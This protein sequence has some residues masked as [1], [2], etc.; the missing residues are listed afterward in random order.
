M[1]NILF[2]HLISFGAILVL[3]A[4]LFPSV[5]LAQAGIDLVVH[6]VEG[7]PLE[8]KVGYT[9]SVYLS[10]LQT[11]GSA[12]NG[13]NK[14]SFK[15][16][17]D[18]HQVEIDSVSTSA[19]LP[20]N[21]LVLVDSSGSMQGTPIQDA[22]SAASSFISS[23]GEKD[24][25]AAAAFNEEMRFLSEFTND[26]QQVSAMMNSV[27]AVNL[28]STCLYDAAY[29]AVQKT[30]T[31]E[32]GRRAIVLLTDGKDYKAG[33][34]CSVHTL[35]DVIRLASEGSTRVPIFT[36]GLGDEIEEKGL[37]RLAEMSGGVYHFAPSSSQLQNIF[38]ALASQLRSEYVLTYTS[39]SAPG[40]HTVAV[41]IKYDNQTAQD[42]RAFTLSELPVTLTI[43]SPTEGQEIDGTTKVAVSLSG[44]GDL[45]EK[46]TF[47]LGETEIGSDATVPYELDYG[48]SSEQLGSQ[49]IT[50][51]A[52]NADGEEITGASV[53]VM[54]KKAAT[55]AISV[56]KTGILDNPLY[57]GLIAG[58]IILLAAVIVLLT[59]RKKKMEPVFN[60]GFDLRDVS[61]SSDP[62]T[63]D[64]ERPIMGKEQNQ[65]EVK[66]IFSILSSDD[67]GMI[68]QQLS[69]THFPSKVG[70]GSSNDIVISK[71]DAAVSRE[72]VVIDQRNDHT[73]ILE[74]FSKDENGNPKLPTYGTYV[75]QK[76]IRERVTPLK[77]GDVIQL[78]SRFKMS[79]NS[80]GNSQGSE[81][82]TID[83]INLGVD[84]KTREIERGEASNWEIPREE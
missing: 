53:G 82:K 62:P 67:A 6:Y 79:F 77:D 12:I 18:S 43:L 51:V 32:S 40:A 16:T 50:A 17:E 42:T 23:L 39:R 78:G 63:I 19:D 55:Q 14:D 37:M 81:A 75:N 38:T 5:A 69:I 36:I 58:G 44:S 64:F 74:V 48:F 72:H 20:M 28:A 27:E 26:R 65:E 7:I 84:G 3:F 52:V 71:K 1:R 33:G 21:I 29:S 41:E 31:L 57:I 73:V 61:G 24:N 54:V 11:N 15:V 49:I 30:A 76:N 22:R 60:E 66:A 59:R 4:L 25:V 8:G 70:R 2:R 83:G 68:G 13:L 46:V 80:V 47:R 34:A 35:D 10:A 45:V 56:K 9:V